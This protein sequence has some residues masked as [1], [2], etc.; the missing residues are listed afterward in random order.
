LN[1]LTDSG[2]GRREEKTMAYLKIGNEKK[3]LLATKGMGQRGGQETKRQGLTHYSHSGRGKTKGKSS[4]L[5]SGGL[6]LTR[7]RGKEPFKPASR[8]GG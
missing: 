6:R 8:V 1:R 2:K 4:Q 3:A 5:N 7:R